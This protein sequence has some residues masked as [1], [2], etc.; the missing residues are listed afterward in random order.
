MEGRIVD[1]ETLKQHALE[2]EAYRTPEWAIEEILKKEMLSLKVFDPC[3]GFGDLAEAA[4]QAGS[5]VYAMDL[6]DQ[7]GFGEMNK[8]FLD[9]K[10]DLS[11][12]TVF[13]NPPFS[14]ATEFVEH[15]LKCKA[16]KIICFQRFAWRESIK[17]ED[18]W[19]KHPANR[20]YICG[21]RANCWRMDLTEEEISSM[22]G[23]TTAHAWFIWER[24]HPQGTL[25]SSIYKP[26]KRKNNDSQD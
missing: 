17:R 20:I 1:Q 19:N 11:S 9:M 2:M 6:S 24:E 26:K 23:T 4:Q 16:R 12:Y 13:M 14:K 3:C 7:W 25:I 18:F 8:D 5:F 15:A 10:L 22:S 21:N